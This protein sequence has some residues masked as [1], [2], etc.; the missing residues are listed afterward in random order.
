MIKVSSI[1][2]VTLYHL[3]QKGT[4][5]SQD[6][7]S[8]FSA[9]GAIAGWTSL[10][11][12]ALTASITGGVTVFSAINDLQYLGSASLLWKGQDTDLTV[13]YRRA[14]MPSFSVAGVPLLNQGVTATATHRMT[15]FFFSFTQR[16]LC[17]QSVD[18]RQ[19][20]REV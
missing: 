16:E 20:A 8:D 9:H 3:Y 2:T 11:T 17:D 7:K 12:R 18:P 13:S 15:E 4:F 19:F 10:V 5:G 1:D 6:S 14:I